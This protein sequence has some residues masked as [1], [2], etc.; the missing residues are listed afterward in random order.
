MQSAAHPTADDIKQIVADAILAERR[1]MATL[2]IQAAQRRRRT[3]GVTDP[4]VFEFTKIANEIAD[5]ST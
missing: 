3:F 5:P 4:I 1:R 2:L